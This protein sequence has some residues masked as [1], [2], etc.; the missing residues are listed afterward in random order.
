M[1]DSELVEERASPRRGDRAREVEL[2]P[3]NPS[4]HVG[5]AAPSFDQVEVEERLAAQVGEVV[6]QLGRAIRHVLD[7]RREDIHSGGLAQPRGRSRR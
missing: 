5:T 6:E 4:L 1:A 3:A 2:R 7:P